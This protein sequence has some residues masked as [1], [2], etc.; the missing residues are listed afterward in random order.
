MCVCVCAGASPY[1]V[2]DL[3]LVLLLLACAA[4]ADEDDCEDDEE[5]QNADD[6]ACD[7]ARGV[8]GFKQNRKTMLVLVKMFVVGYKFFF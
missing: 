1:L 5:Q 7:D 3:L 2:A 6:S 8:G 4:A